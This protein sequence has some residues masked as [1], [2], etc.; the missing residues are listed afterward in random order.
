MD[1]LPR[2]PKK[3]PPNQ[4]VKLSIL[5]RPTT[6]EDFNLQESEDD[7]ELGNY[8]LEPRDSF[9]HNT[10]K[11]TDCNEYFSYNDTYS[12]SVKSLELNKQT[13]NPYYFLSDLSSNFSQVELQA[14]TDEDEEKNYYIPVGY[15]IG[16]SQSI[17][18]IEQVSYPM[19]KLPRKMS[20]KELE[21]KFKSTRVKSRF[22]CV[23]KES[24]HSFGH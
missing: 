15:E 20:K 21:N 14:D 1:K 6:N 11:N 13:D 22:K 24:A 4:R 8:Y 9:R 12:N 19:P 5:S 18:S 2:L 23:S 17:P 10:T 3:L 16:K 7:E